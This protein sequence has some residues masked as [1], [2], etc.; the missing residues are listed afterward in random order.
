MRIIPFARRALVPS[1]RRLVD[2]RTRA[3]NHR[4]SRSPLHRVVRLT[5]VPDV[6]RSSTSR[7]PRARR[8]PHRALVTDAIIDTGRSTSHRDVTSRRRDADGDLERRRSGGMSEGETSTVLITGA[9]GQIG[10]ALAPMVCAGAAT[11]RSTK[12]ALRLLDVSFAAQALEG[13]KM[14]LRDAAFDLVESVECFT[15]ADEACANV[16]VAIMVGGFPR[17]SGMERKDVLGKNVAIYKAQAAA[18]ASK[19]KRDVK[20]VVVANP[21]NTNAKILAK[22]APSIPKTNITCLTRLDHNRALAQLSERSGKPTREV[23]NTIIWGN[24]SSTQYP[25][26]NHATIGG[27]PARDVVGDDAWLRG[28][29]IAKVQQRGKA[30]IEARGL[31]SAMSAANAVSDHL[32]TWLYEG[33]RPG[34]HVPMQIPC[35]VVVIRTRRFS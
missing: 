18:L 27:K 35:V 13:V 34:E 5:D 2:S 31:S 12:I 19:A 9:A 28:E 22:F 7:S 20:I 14:E 32:R 8:A 16:D 4:P 29:F 25:D 23:K 24:H 26:V 1:S 30:V 21:A 33:T 15:D 10:Y 11:G 17:K 3:A 6:S